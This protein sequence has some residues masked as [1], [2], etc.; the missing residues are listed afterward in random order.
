[1]N[2]LILSY[3]RFPEG[4]AGSLRQYAFGKLLSDLGYTVCFVGMGYGACH[5]MGDYKGFKYT[6]LR[7]NQ[8]KPGLMGCFVNY[9]GYKSRLE[10]FI[11]KHY[12][13]SRVECI[14]VDDIP[15]NALLF[16]KRLSKREHIMLVHDSVEWYS[17]EQFRFKRFA[18]SYILKDLNNRFLIDKNFKV[19]AISKYLEKHFLE[20]GLEIVRIP[21]VMDIDNLGYE[22]KIRRERLTVLYAGTP[23]KKDYLKEMIKGILL[24]GNDLIKKIDFR[25]I[26]ISKDQLIDMHYVSQQMLDKLGDSLNVVGRIRRKD[27]LKNL[28]EADFTVLLRSPTQRYAK[29]GFPT[30]VVESLASGTPVIC[31]ITSDLG[32]YIRDGENGI[33]V[34]E[35]SAE[36]FSLAIKRALHLT[37]EQRKIMCSNARKCAEG[38]FNYELYI[39]NV[40]E[41]LGGR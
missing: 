28:E 37:F 10:S 23:G 7:T 21:A 38:Y 2:I 27:V 9:F 31:N 26:G 41:L 12:S 13:N 34:N 33:I 17:P 20:K 40:K 39:N 11:K 24:L 5:E 1:M 6:S 19:I 36:A 25:L 29:A 16:L 14:L 15:L 8:D 32:D 18:P 22:K 30:K 3:Y 4:D 35:C